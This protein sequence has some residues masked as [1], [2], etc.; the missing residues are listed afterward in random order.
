MPEDRSPPQH[1]EAEQ[2]LLGALL[3]NNEAIDR[4]AGLE[5]EHFFD[6]THQGIYAAAR[7][8]ILGGGRADAVT[9]S[10]EF[11]VAYLAELTAS[12]PGLAAVAPYAKLIRTAAQRRAAI[13]AALDLIDRAHG[14]DAEAWPSDLDHARQYLDDA[15][16]RGTDGPTSFGEALDEALRLADEAGKRGNG[17]AG[18]PYGFTEIDQRTGG[19]VGGELIILAGGTGEGKTALAV[20]IAVKNAM[21]GVPVLF[22][23]HEMRFSDLAL[24]AVAMRTGIPYSKQRRGDLTAIDWQAV[25]GASR[26]MRDLPIFFDRNCETPGQLRQ[27]VRTM[28]RT[29]DL[30]L[31]VVDY[32]QLLD[33]DRR[34]TNDVERISQISRG[35]KLVAQHLDIPVLALSQYSQGY[36]KEDRLPRLDDL[37]GSG[38]IKQDA[39]TAILLHRKAAR[40]E[41]KMRASDEDTADYMDARAKWLACRNELDVVIGKVRAGETGHV[42]LKANLAVNQFADMPAQRRGEAA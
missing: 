40:H 41:E 35:L 37:R 38:T 23:S 34:T 36:L 39:S 16:A 22:G 20:D 21:Q 42:K 12:T 25:V 32:L 18:I 33:S 24:R 15:T 17:L 27:L 9:L 5:P 2:S 14:A 13:D 1:L 11:D 29:H 28:K 30:G 10:G 6:V 4:C 26:G 3:F 19:M 31:V 8:M 7:K